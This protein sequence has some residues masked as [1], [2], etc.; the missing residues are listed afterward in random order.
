MPVPQMN[1]YSD[2][3]SNLPDCDCCFVSSEPSCALLSECQDI[4]NKNNSLLVTKERFYIY[5]KPSKCFQLGISSEKNIIKKLKSYR[6][7]D[8]TIWKNRE[9]KSQLQLFEN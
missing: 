8:E 2:F 4:E 7:V 1:Q 5:K 9:K 3:F 6:A